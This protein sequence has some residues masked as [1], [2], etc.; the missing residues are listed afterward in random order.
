[1]HGMF[2]ETTN[3]TTIDLGS[4][5]TSRVTSMDS[6]FWELPNLRTIYVSNS[7]TTANV[8]SGGNMFTNDTSLV[9]GNGTV[10]DANHIDKEYARIDTANTPGYFTRATLLSNMLGGRINN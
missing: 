10:Y 6:M 5:N 2:M 1:M 4:F 3:L 7:F 9:G 8:T